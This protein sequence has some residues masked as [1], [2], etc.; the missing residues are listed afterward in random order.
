M[1]GDFLERPCFPQY[2]MTEKCRRKAFK[3]RITLITRV[4]LATSKRVR[5]VESNLWDSAREKRRTTD[6]A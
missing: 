4:G 1:L 5:M 6:K 2:G 3:E